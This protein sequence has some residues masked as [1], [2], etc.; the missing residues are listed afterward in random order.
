MSEWIAAWTGSASVLVGVTI[1][2]ALVWVIDRFEVMY[3]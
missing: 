2:L 3:R 1:T